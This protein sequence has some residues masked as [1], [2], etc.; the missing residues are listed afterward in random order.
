MANHKSAEKA[1]RKSEN[2]RLRN[3][4]RRSRIKTSIKKVITAISAGDNNEARKVLV[5]AQSEIDRGVTKGVM[6]KGTASR[7]VKRLAAK[8]KAMIA[9]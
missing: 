5:M 8:V 1:A 9:A 6:K 3:R 2:L 4:A 7:T